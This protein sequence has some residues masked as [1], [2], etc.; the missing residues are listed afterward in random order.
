[1]DKQP[2]SI[3]TLAGPSEREDEG[4]LVRNLF[5]LPRYFSTKDVATKTV[6]TIQILSS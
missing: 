3:K 1:M 5:Q 4:G 6:A 2:P